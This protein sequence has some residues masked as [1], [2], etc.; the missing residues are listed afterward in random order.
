[1]QPYLTL[2]PNAADGVWA[3]DDAG[4]VLPENTYWAGFQNRTAA[5]LM[6]ETLAAGQ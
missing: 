2:T 6:F 5:G 4:A 3:V 1:M